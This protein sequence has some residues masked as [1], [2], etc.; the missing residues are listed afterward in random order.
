MGE[1]PDLYMDWHLIQ[2]HSGL[3]QWHN[4][5]VYRKISCRLKPTPQ[6][7]SAHKRLLQISISIDINGTL[8]L[9]KFDPN[10]E[11]YN[12]ICS[13][14]TSDTG[15][16]IP[17][18]DRRNAFV[19]N[20]LSLCEENCELVDYNK[21]TKKVK[22]SCDTKKGINSN[23]DF[24]FKK[25]DFLKSFTDVKSILNLNIMK[26]FKVALSIKNLKNNYGFFIMLIL[27]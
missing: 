13:I 14:T 18:K 3:Q 17:L 15:T 4:Y 5:H 25:D 27:K 10:S 7:G 19:N 24:K 11:Y 8:D 12:D 16:D 1:L 21:E 6:N 23:Y 2:N 22:C 9:K 26:C 20:N